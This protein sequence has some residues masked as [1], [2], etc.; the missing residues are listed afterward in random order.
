MVLEGKW[1]V[2]QAARELGVPYHV[3]WH[4]I[5]HHTTTSGA[6]V[7]KPAVSADDA[8]RI[9]SETVWK[10]KDTIDV[11]FAEGRISSSLLRELRELLKDAMQLRA[12]MVEQQMQW[13]ELFEEL[14]QFILTELTPEQR[15][16]IVPILEKYEK[17]RKQEEAKPDASRHRESLRRPS[18]VRGE[19]TGN[20]PLPEAEGGSDKVLQRKLS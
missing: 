11:M 1:T 13:K 3:M 19:N 20:Q 18:V 7:G 2:G 16:K 4:H 8:A 9:L 5:Q 17:L 6:V 15:Q 14:L 12:H 10:L